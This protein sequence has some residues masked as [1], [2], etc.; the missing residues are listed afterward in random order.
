MQQVR[1]AKGLRLTDATL[2]GKIEQLTQDVA[3]R[4]GLESGLIEEILGPEGPRYRA[5]EPPE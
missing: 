2:L 4:Y 3:V 1:E 5:L